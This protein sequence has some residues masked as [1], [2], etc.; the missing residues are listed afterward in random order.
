MWFQGAL[1]AEKR[2]VIFPEDS[3]FF[4]QAVNR[5]REYDGKM[6]LRLED[7]ERLRARGVES[8]D[9]ADAV[10]GALWFRIRAPSFRFLKIKG[11]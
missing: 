7:K 2:T 9:R 8:P 6:R 11:M 5:R 3:L 10:F 4:A 1:A